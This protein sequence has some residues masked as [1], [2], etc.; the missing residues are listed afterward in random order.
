MRNIWLGY[1]LKNLKTM[2]IIDKLKQDWVTIVSIFLGSLT[3]VILCYVLG[4]LSVNL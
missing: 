1:Q 2:K 3:T 4:M